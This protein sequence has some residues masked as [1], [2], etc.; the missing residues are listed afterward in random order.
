MSGL[1]PFLLESGVPY[2]ELSRWTSHCFR[3]GSGV[4][5]L[6]E[7]GIAA[8]VS[9]GEWAD[10]RSARPYASADE[11]RAVGLAA[12]SLVVDASDDDDD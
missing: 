2:G 1:Q 5:V 9:H 12:A 7:R 11:Q 6:E 4:D 8:M 10:P 3:R